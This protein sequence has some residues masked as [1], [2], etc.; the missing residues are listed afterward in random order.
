MATILLMEDDNLLRE[1]LAEALDDAGFNVA[2]A[3]NGIEGLAF[4]ATHQPDLFI[5]DIIMDDGEGIG[6]IINI[7]RTHIDLPIL[8]ISGNPLYLNNSL[9][10]SANHAMLKP[11]SKAQLLVTINMLLTDGARRLA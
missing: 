5:T 3:S 6:S 1:H 9:K 11:F 10:L 8:A 7:R 4:V 2:M